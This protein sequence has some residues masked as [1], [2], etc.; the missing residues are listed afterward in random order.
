MR[1]MNV[2]INIIICAVL[3][4]PIQATLA[5]GYPGGSGGSGNGPGPGPGG[6]PPPTKGGAGGKAESCKDSTGG[7]ILLVNGAERFSVTDLE[8]KGLYP[9]VL[10]REYD[11]QS[12]LDTPLGAGWDFS[13]MR[14]MHIY[15]DTDKDAFEDYSKPY[16]EHVKHI[17]VDHTCGQKDYWVAYTMSTADATSLHTIENQPLVKGILTSRD[18]I[19][20]QLYYDY[21]QV[22]G[23][24][25][26]FFVQKISGD[27]INKL[28]PIS[29]NAADPEQTLSKF[30]Y[31]NVKSGITYRFDELGRLYEEENEQGQIHRYTYDSRGLLPLIGTPNHGVV[32]DQTKL[33]AKTYKLTRIEE[34]AADGIS[35]GNFVEFFYNDTTGRLTE[36]HASDGRIVSYTHDV[37]ASSSTKGNLVAVSAS[38]D[39]VSAYEYTDSYDVHNISS[40]QEEL[41]ISP[42]VNTYDD[43]DRVIKQVRDMGDGRYSWIVVEYPTKY[44]KTIVKKSI[45]DASGAIVNGYNETVKTVQFSGQWQRPNWMETPEG[46]CIH[47]TYDSR[48]HVSGASYYNVTCTTAKS[49]STTPEISNSSN[50]DKYGRQVSKTT[51]LENGDIVQKIWTY[52]LSNSTALIGSKP[53]IV[54]TTLT[55]SGATTTEELITHDRYQDN[56]TLLGAIHQQVGDGEPDLDTVYTYDEKHRISTKTDPDGNVIQYLYEGGSLFPTTIQHLESGAPITTKKRTIAY[57]NR[58]NIT[59]IWDGNNNHTH[60]D[61]DD[62]NRLIHETNALGEEAIYTYT[63]SLLT[64]IEIG[65]TTE[66]GGSTVNEGQVI[67]L[68]YDGLG[69]LTKKEVKDDNGVLYN[70][71]TILNDA[72][73]KPLSVEDALGHAWVYKYDSEG[74]KVEA[75]DPEGHVTKYG[76]N[77]FGQRIWALDAKMH[78]TKY[79][80]NNLGKIKRIEQCGVEPCVIT[81]IA[82]DAMGRTNAITDANDNNTIYVYDD[83][84][85]IVQEVGAKGEH[86]YTYNGRGEVKTEI[87]GRGNYKVFDYYSWGGLHTIKY[88]PNQAMEVPERTV[89]WTYDDEGNVRDV[90]DTSIQEGVFRTKSYDALNRLHT[91]TELYVPGTSIVKTYSYDVVGNLKEFSIDDGTTTTE[92]FHYNKL[93]RLDAAKLLG[94]P[95]AFDY[96]D[97]G[98][99]KT[100][101]YNST[102][103]SSTYYKNRWIKEI[104]YTNNGTEQF[105]QEYIPDDVG[106]I[107]AITRTYGTQIE[108]ISYG[109]DGINRVTSATNPSVSGLPSSESYDYDNAGNRQGYTYE[110]WNR[111]K[112]AFG[113]TYSYDNDGNVN[114]IDGIVLAYDIEGRLTQYSDNYYEYDPQW[115]RIKK[116][117]STTTTYYVWDANRL[118]AEYDQNGVRHTTYGYMPGENNPAEVKIDS[119][120]YNVIHDHLKTV[121]Q[122]Q[123][124]EGNIVWQ[125]HYEAYGNSVI[126]DDYDQ[127][128]NHIA[129]NIRFPG[130]YYD[131]ET[132]LYYNYYRYYDPEMGRYVTSD[133]IGLDGGINT[134]TYVLNNP[135]SFT[136]PTGLC[137]EDACIVE[138]ALLY[139]AGQALV[140]ALT[141]GVGTA[142]IVNSMSNNRPP[143]GSKGIDETPWSGDHQGIKKGVG[144][145]LKDKVKIDPEGNVWVQNPD[146]SWTNHGDAGSYTGSGKPSGRKGKDRC[147]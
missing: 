109:Y 18:A 3:N 132:G 28:Q 117:T 74:R 53:S 62:R 61:Y 95:Y 23:S 135:I 36:A 41:N 33:V 101:T 71:A 122:L 31:T 76:Y 54:K 146:G 118:L 115:R 94:S 139:T 131:E 103:A 24:N 123:D 13:F 89:S 51:T 69:N 81:E 93:G 50:Y 48:G 104:I 11:S 137:L 58:G 19:T 134:Y 43:K 38:G 119:N 46:N 9:I 130:Q 127:D 91:E 128:L 1:W 63:G 85:R 17:V 102:I 20:G 113:K 75:K 112:N 14:R 90:T 78:Q 37:T 8:I 145:G 40:I 111:I 5:S 129:F 72:N 47:N 83:I 147:K 100:R 79:Y 64:Q 7:S 96:Y 80:Y 10:K 116:E 97:N 49:G 59:D 84:G 44:G 42:W 140:D 106:N 114:S 12:T 29:I 107:S 60:R 6:A 105:K 65:R 133:P 124:I 125:A 86:T 22:P 55:H 87:N 108:N 126:N 68:Y 66:D 39:K 35:T 121:L 57:D 99:E 34:Y 98:Q 26:Q 30:Q 16:V 136:D 144:V 92:T 2:L 67:K 110:Q 4:L 143:P 70:M 56:P 25:M 52:D 88:Y 138:G 32:P 142:A 82:Y 77:S 21:T 45:R 15:P 27:Q 73:G 141:V 120:I